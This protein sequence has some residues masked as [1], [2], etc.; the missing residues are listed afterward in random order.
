VLTLQ[1]AARM[2]TLRVALFLAWRQLTRTSLW[3][4]SLIIVIMTL[5]FLNLVVV[6]GVL[7]GLVEGINVA[8]RQLYSGDVFIRPSENRT[9]IDGT[10]K[11][12]GVLDSLPEVAY[13]SARYVVGATI[14]ANYGLSRRADE[15]PDRTSTSVAGIDPD[16]EDST[17][18]IDSL[19]IAGKFLEPTDTGVVVMGADLLTQYFGGGPNTGNQTIDGVEVGSRIRITINGQTQEMTVKGIVRSKVDDVSRRVYMIDRELR[20]LAAITDLNRAEIAVVAKPG[21]TPTELQSA[22]I[23]A[24]AARN[25][26]RVQTWQEAQPQFVA[27]VQQTFNTLG[28]FIGSIGLFIASITVFI[29]IFINAINRR[30]Y[31]GIM[32]AVGVHALSIEL[33]YIFQALAYAL[34]GSAI[35][36]VVVYTLLVPFFNTHPINFPFSDGIL[37][38]PVFGTLIR[39][40]VLLIITVFAGFIPARIVV[41]Q[42]TVD[43]ILGR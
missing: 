39:A 31:I 6:S 21:V 38:A 30:K 14:E 17:T 22:L 8:T 5:T 3:S 19:L 42:P 25:D 9:T 29:V 33:A 11:I 28:N 24:G 27:D 40:G 32:K 34:A 18:N 26:N 7:V 20:D 4:T 36:I 41:K 35:G 13:Y 23:R 1:N 37:V 2:A 12:V 10:A 16:K 15:L 43:A